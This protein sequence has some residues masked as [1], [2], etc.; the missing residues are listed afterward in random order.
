M[1]VKAVWEQLTGYA[2]GSPDYELP[3][4]GA[5]PIMGLIDSKIGFRGS[6]IGTLLSKALPMTISSALSNPDAF[7]TSI[8]VPASKGMSQTRAIQGM[9]GLLRAYA[10]GG[11]EGIFMRHPEQRANLNS[12]AARYVDALE[13]NG[14]DSKQVITSAK[15]DIMR[16]LYADFYEGFVKGD[17]ARMHDAAK[18]IYR[19]QGTKDGLLRSVESR[20]EKTGR[21]PLTETERTRVLEAFEG[22]VPDFVEKTFEGEE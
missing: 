14:Y 9:M 4:R 5:G 18:R 20:Q 21:P 3:F 13:R 8:V 15:G 12:L 17:E 7:I 22:A 1:L 16:T 10:E 11:N 19:V 2:P 6:R